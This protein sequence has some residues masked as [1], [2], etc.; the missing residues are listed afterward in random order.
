[1]RQRRRDGAA[2]RERGKKIRE[3]KRHYTVSQVDSRYRVL[4]RWH[5]ARGRTRAFSMTPSIRDS[6]SFNYVTA[7]VARIRK[8]G[9]SIFSMHNKTFVGCDDAPS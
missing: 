6:I 8:H 1:M 3:E 2:G 9:I 4:S 7:L 5:Y